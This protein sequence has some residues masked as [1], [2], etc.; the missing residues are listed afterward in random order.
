[1]AV[2]FH[3]SAVIRGATDLALLAQ[4]TELSRKERTEVCDTLYTAL[5]VDQIRRAGDVNS[6][7][8]RRAELVIAEWRRQ[9]CPDNEVYQILV[10]GGKTTPSGQHTPINITPPLFPLF[11][12]YTEFVLR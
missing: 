12:G 1:M 7:T 10:V 6:I 5:M 3:E 9:G 4:G 2:A 11:R 8:V